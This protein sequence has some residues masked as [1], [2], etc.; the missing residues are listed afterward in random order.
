VEKGPVP[1][2]TGPF[3]SYGS[4]YALLRA[5]VTRYTS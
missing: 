4:P 5:D 3:S 2:G 1:R